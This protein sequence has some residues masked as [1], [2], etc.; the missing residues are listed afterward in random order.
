[1]SSP[2]SP[3][4][5]PYPE[6]MNPY[7]SQSA[8]RSRRPSAPRSKRGIAEAVW[9]RLA[10]H[11]EGHVEHRLQASLAA[12][13]LRPLG[14]SRFAREYPAW[15]GD[16]RPGFVDFL[17]L[18]RHNRLH[19]V[20][21]K[22]GTADVKVV[23]Q[24]LDYATWVAA[25]DS[26]I[27]A[28]RSWPE[29]TSSQDFPVLDFV[30]SPKP[31]V[32][33]HGHAVG[34]YLAGQL[35][36][37]AGDLQRRVWTVADPLSE[38]P[39]V[40]GPWTRALPISN[41]LIAAPVQPARWAAQI[42][43]TLQG[44]EP[45]TRVPLLHAGPDAAL[46]PA[47]R[48]IYADLATRGL[49][50]RW[51]MHH[52]SSQAFAL[53]LFAPL[54]AD[55][56][57][58]IFRLIG[59]PALTVDEPVFEY[60]DEADRLAE[61]RPASPHRTQVD[62]LLRGIADTGKRLAALIEVK[63]TEMDFGHCSAYA[64]PTNP[65][66]DVCC[67]PGLFGDRPDECFQLANHGTGRRRY[68]H[69]LNSIPVIQPRGSDDNGGCIVRQGRNQ[70]M[71]NLALAQLMLAEGDADQ[72]AYV[73]CAPAAHATIWRRFAEVQA[74]FP[75]TPGRVTRALAAEQV[76]V[77]QPDGGAALTAHYPPPALTAEI[78]RA[79][80]EDV[81]EK[82][83][84]EGKFWRI[85]GK[86]YDDMTPDER[87]FAL[88]VRLMTPPGAI[89]VNGFALPGPREW[90]EDDLAEFAGELGLNGGA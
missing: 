87:E 8:S 67:S 26:D 66:R 75:D 17:G 24:T 79:S 84:K 61:A 62:V 27:R 71:R 89:A 65:H 12:T 37:L 28:E 23:L 38:I 59:L 78:A 32:G 40:S 41:A 57:R 44:E 54:D 14:L 43:H 45:M 48:P 49:A 86:H 21:T 10:G 60:S 35:E 13:D 74:A 5:S 55:G 29:P 15:R 56:I 30:L 70:P 36:A 7:T 53:N 90:S 22:V 34:P 50:H 52:R 4:P 39:Q 58:A 46:L 19:I 47:A 83:P 3:T 18:D 11:D 68:E 77:L 20:E 42:A 82:G 33:G 81:T 73:L 2:A 25:H 80:R 88:R 16:G 1:M 85:L 69:Y 64:N 51:A 31:G 76:A 63:F 6:S 9:R 72:C